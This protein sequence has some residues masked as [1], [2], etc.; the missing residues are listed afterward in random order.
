LAGFKCGCKQQPEA[1]SRLVEP[2]ISNKQRLKE[3]IS[4]PN[5]V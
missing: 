1:A 3:E 4:D 2:E 5:L